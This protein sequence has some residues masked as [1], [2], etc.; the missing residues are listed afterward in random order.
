VSQSDPQW[1][2]EL[3]RVVHNAKNA[4]RD[5]FQMSNAPVIIYRICRLRRMVF[6]K[7]TCFAENILLRERLAMSRHT[8]G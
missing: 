2:S 4:A 7:S 8:R 6:V 3:E 5:F 1:E